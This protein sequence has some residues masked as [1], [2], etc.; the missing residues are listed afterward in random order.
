MLAFAVIF[1]LYIE[2]LSNP[3]LEGICHIKVGHAIGGRDLLAFP[4]TGD[5]DPVQLRAVS[6][7]DVCNIYSQSQGTAVDEGKVKVRLS[8]FTLDVLI[9]GN[10]GLGSHFIGSEAFNLPQFL[11]SSGHKANLVVQSSNGSFH[12]FLHFGTKKSSQSLFA[13]RRVNIHCTRGTTQIA[14]LRDHSSRSNNLYALT[15][16]NREGSTC[17]RLSSFQL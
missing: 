6:F 14:A 5:G 13:L 9:P 15:R 12:H 1:A 8:A 3:S 4:G 16:Q 2:R 17:L 11:D 10:L 7:D